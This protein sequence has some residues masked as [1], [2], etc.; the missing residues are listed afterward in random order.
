VH[1]AGEADAGNV[2]GAQVRAGES[3]ANRDRA[4]APPVFRVL[5]GPADLG[6]GEGCV[7]FGCGCEQ[8]ALFVDDQGARAAG[9][10]VNA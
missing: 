3:F 7:F 10:Y 9:A 8:A 4:G 5:L 2:V 1:L 6:R